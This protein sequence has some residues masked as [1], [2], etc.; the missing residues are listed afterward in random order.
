[1]LLCDDAQPNPSNPKKVDVHGLL[2]VIQSITDPFVYPR[3]HSFTIYLALTEGRGEGELQIVVAS[4]DSAAKIYKSPS[5]SIRFTNDP[6]C[7]YGV[8][9]YVHTCSFPQAGL[10]WV[11]CWYN[12]TMI[13]HQ[14]LEVI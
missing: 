6:L 12:G 2:S 4:A 14:P 5:Y 1:M 8:I 9:V 3:V 10:Y 13:D 11:E 7:V